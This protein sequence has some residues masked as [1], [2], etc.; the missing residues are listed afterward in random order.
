MTAKNFWQKTLTFFHFVK[1]T[2]EA[3]LYFVGRLKSTKFQIM[4]TATILLFLGKLD[5]W[6]WLAVAGAYMGVNFLQ[7]KFIENGGLE[8]GYNGKAG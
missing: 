1:A 4:V 2:K 8:N 5:Q 6:G 7:K 3:W